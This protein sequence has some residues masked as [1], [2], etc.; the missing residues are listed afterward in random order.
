MIISEIKALVPGAGKTTTLVRT[1][2]QRISSKSNQ[3]ILTPSNKNKQN[4][5]RMLSEFGVINAHK[6]VKTFREFKQ[7]FVRA[8][9][10]SRVYNPESME[11]EFKGSTNQ[12]FTTESKFHYKKVYDVVYID[13]ASMISDKEIQDLI[14]HWKIKHLVL[15]GDANQFAPIPNYC[16]LEGTV[17]SE[18]IDEGEFYKLPIDHQIL[19]NKSMRAKDEKL[20][21]VIKLIKE[22]KF[23][24]SIGRFQKHYDLDLQKGDWNIA[25]TNAGCDRINKLYESK[26]LVDKVIVVENDKKHNFSKSEILDVNDS[27]FERLRNELA[28]EDWLSWD[29]WQKYYLKP[30]MC[31][32]AHKLQGTTIPEGRVRI[33]LED[34]AVGLQNAEVDY[35]E[36]VDTI[37]K[38]LYIAVSRACDFDQIQMLWFGESIKNLFDGAMRAIKS[39]SHNLQILNQMDNDMKPMVDRDISSNPTWVGAADDKY[40]DELEAVKQLLMILNQE[41]EVNVLEGED[42]Y[43]KKYRADRRKKYSEEEVNFALNHKYREC[44]ERF[45]WSKGKYERI[46]KFGKEICVGVKSADNK[47]FH[48][49]H[50]DK[51]ERKEIK[52]PKLSKSLNPSGMQSSEREID[53]NNDDYY[54]E[55]AWWYE[56]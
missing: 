18:W 44:Y 53:R 52:K 3:I 31:V 40:S 33:H 56:F 23:L 9:T 10:Q 22:G 26:G 36:T 37:Q 11:Y 48:P 50:L 43:L 8:T 21:K 28:V 27:R 6:Y 13:E 29:E 5:I 54:E 35:E 39:C 51:Q 7:N 2:L 4:I 42:E 12:Y 19:L 47:E 32:T 46:K 30:A 55:L 1:F 24:E 25:Y 14:K 15:C 41:T 17:E 38:F 16:K 49:N 45:G 34:I 20:E